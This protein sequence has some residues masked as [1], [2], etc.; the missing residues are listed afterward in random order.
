MGRKRK[1][2]QE[3]MLQA[4]NDY[5]SGNKSITQISN[6]LECSDF[7]IR[8]WVQ[9]HASLGEVALLD[10]NRNKI[11]SKELK[12]QVISDY[13]S[14]KGSAAYLSNKYNISSSSIVT[15][16]VFNYNNGIEIQDYDPKH[17]VYTMK[18]RK[19]TLDER[20]EI[21]EYCIANHLCYKLAADKYSIPYSLVYQWVHRYLKEGNVGLGYS[22]KGPHKKV[23]VPTSDQERLQLENER[24]KQEL[25]RKE[26][27]IEILKKKQYFAELLYSPKSNKKNRT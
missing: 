9:T 23:I 25:E 12:K 19:T 21:V 8:S 14:G 10:S 15:N 18:A 13:L 11:Y 20:I 24:L 4:I 22:K 16:W 3:I 1:F 26:L 27:E 5:K 7:S 17:E 2:T 6:D